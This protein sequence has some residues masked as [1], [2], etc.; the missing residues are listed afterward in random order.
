M[1]V[2]LSAGCL[3]WS[4]SKAGWLLALA[5]AFVTLLR[6][7][8]S[9]KVRLALAALVLLL[10]SGGFYARY[11]GYL[12]R[13]ATSAVARFDYWQ[14]AARIGCRDRTGA[15]AAVLRRAGGVSRGRDSSGPGAAPARGGRDQPWI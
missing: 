5:L 13:G 10:G 11:S 15:H 9:G 8:L 2:I 7:P 6:L 1:F 4:G 3:V 12:E 14:A